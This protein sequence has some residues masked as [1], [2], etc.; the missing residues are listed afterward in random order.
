MKKQFSTIDKQPPPTLLRQP[1]E[2]KKRPRPKPTKRPSISVDISNVN[3]NLS[4]E[5]H[6]SINDPQKKA[7]PA[8]PYSK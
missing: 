7:I 1:R 2:A 5:I 3:S 6:V 4:N 8:P